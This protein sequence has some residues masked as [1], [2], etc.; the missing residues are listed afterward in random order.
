MDDVLL[1]YKQGASWD[2]ERFVADLERSECYHPP[3]KLEDGKP[4]TFLE[5]TFRW[6]GGRF[7]Y[8]PKNDNEVGEAPPQG[9]GAMRTLGHMARLS[10]SEPY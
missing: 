4:G 2:H 10:R 9:S 3:L 1:C 6:E 7:R 5:T 8:W